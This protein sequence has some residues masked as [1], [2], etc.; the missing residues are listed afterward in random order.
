MK[1]TFKKSLKCV[2]TAILIIAALPFALIASL[3]W[4]IAT[5]CK[6]AAKSGKTA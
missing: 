4:V 5:L 6:M 1:D 2:G 3:V